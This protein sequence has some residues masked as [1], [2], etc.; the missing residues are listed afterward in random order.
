MTTVTTTVLGVG[1]GRFNEPLQ[2]KNDTSG[3]M[4]GSLVEDFQR[5]QGRSPIV[6]QIKVQTVTQFRHVYIYGTWTSLDR[7]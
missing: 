5:A 1:D 3:Y 6:V 2:G 7:I 4:Y